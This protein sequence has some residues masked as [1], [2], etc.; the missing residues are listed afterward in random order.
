MYYILS[1]RNSTRKML[2]NFRFFN[3]FVERYCFEFQSN[4]SFVLAKPSFNNLEVC[5]IGLREA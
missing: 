2:V 4:M 5:C 3:V 1:Y